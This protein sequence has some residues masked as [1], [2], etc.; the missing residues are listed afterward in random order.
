MHLGKTVDDVAIMTGLEVRC[1]GSGGLDPINSQIVT[2]N[3]TSGNYLQTGAALTG[4]FATSAV[5]PIFKDTAG[6]PLPVGK[7]TFV[8]TVTDPATG[9]TAVTA[10]FAGQQHLGVEVVAHDRVAIALDV[11]D[12]KHEMKRLRGCNGVLEVSKIAPGR[13][14][15]DYDPH[16]ILGETLA[17]GF[18]KKSP[19]APARESSDHAHEHRGVFGDR[20]EL[21]FA[22]GSGAA[23][24]AGWLAER[25]GIE[26]LPLIFYLIAY[27]LGGYYT[28][29]E[30]VENARHRRLRIDSLMIV[31]AIGAA[32]S[33]AATARRTSSRVP[34]GTLPT[35]TGTA[36]VTREP[37]RKMPLRDPR[38]ST[39]QPSSAQRSNWRRALWNSPS[40][41]ST[42]SGPPGASTTSPSRAT[43]RTRCR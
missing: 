26:T 32:A 19:T 11:G 28:T 14:L 42:R 18:R 6:N 23:L 17:Q 35:V 25:G 2:V 41:V 24:A 12:V 1:V 43:R 33:V 22:L 38:S 7:H 34:S 20:T 29:L 4:V 27:A 13:V 10:P 40:L 21:Y 3:S 15:V 16:L 36:P 39:N 37:P 5:N 9:C 8:V 31:A 30:A